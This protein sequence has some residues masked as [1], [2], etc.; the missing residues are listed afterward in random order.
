MAANFKSPISP[1][2]A[3]AP[4]PVNDSPLL[5]EDATYDNDFETRVESVLTEDGVE[6]KLKRYVSEGAQP[7]LLVHGF[8]ANGY[9]FDLPHQNHN[10]ALYLAERGYDVWVA[11]FRGCGREPYRCGIKHWNH[12]IDHLAAF[13]APALVEG[14]SRSTGKRPVWIG[15]SMGGM[16]LYMYLQGIVVEPANADFL[17]TSDSELAAQRNRS[18]LG[19]IA[20]ASP[21]AFYFGG[22]DWA[23]GLSS[24]PLSKA[25][26]GWTIQYLRWTN[27]FF[28]RISLKGAPGMADSLPRVARILAA[29]GPFAACLYNVENVYPD[30]GYS[31][32][33]WSGDSVST[34]M[35]AQI[36]ALSRDSDLKDYYGRHNYTENMDLITAPLFF[37]SGS[38][39]F[40]GPE[41]IRVYGYETVSSPIKRFKLY[42]GY[43]HTDL[44]IGKR[45][46]EEVYPDI[47]SWI[48]HL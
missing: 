39:D 28:R 2:N 34:R 36:L 5:L 30:V 38:E 9:C 32:L 27:N 42:P 45:V 16:V 1:S 15:H 31:L 43:G 8:F 46:A 11:S 40:A 37:I 41:N 35:T 14:V 25:L 21:P 24:M 33:K 20:M 19:G 47:L 23:E 22:K 4:R 48:D 17:V 26:T 44:V 12:S 13:D 10:M 7:V 29:K 6:L 18:I 3:F